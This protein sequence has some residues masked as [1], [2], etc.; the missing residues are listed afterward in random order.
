MKENQSKIIE[1]YIF[2]SCKPYNY[3]IRQQL[4]MLQQSHNKKN[5]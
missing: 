3:H 5:L 4:V 1:S 2:K